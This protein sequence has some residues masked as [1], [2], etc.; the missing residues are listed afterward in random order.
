VSIQ[1]VFVTFSLIRLCLLLLSLSLSRLSGKHSG[2][3]SF[4]DCLSDDH[5][6]KLVS[7]VHCVFIDIAAISIPFVKIIRAACLLVL[8]EADIFLVC[9]DLRVV[10]LF[11]LG[12]KI[13]LV[14]LILWQ[15][16]HNL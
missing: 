9:H 5:R 1:I 3:G 6:I 16:K 8:I 10:V 7:V 13:S 4:L 14:Y 15:I 11:D 2:L 12:A